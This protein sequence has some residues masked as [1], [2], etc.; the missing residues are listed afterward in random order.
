M[1]LENQFRQSQADY[2]IDRFSTPE[3]AVHTLEVIGG[4]ASVVSGIDAVCGA[5]AAGTSIAGPVGG[6]VAGV[7][8]II[9]GIIGIVCMEK[10]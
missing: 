6:I 4:A 9:V 8:A 5:V 1:E 3:K 2:I 7:A 10:K